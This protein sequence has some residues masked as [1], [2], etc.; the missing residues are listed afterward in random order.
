VSATTEQT[1]AIFQTSKRLVVYP[2]ARTTT[3][4]WV[5]SEPYVGLPMEVD[6]QTLGQKVLAALDASQAGVPHPTD[7]KAMDEPFLR[8]AEEKS[9]ARAAHGSRALT[10]TRSS[11]EIRFY[12][13]KRADRRGAFLPAE[14]RE[15]SVP[16]DASPPDL[17]RQVARA[18]ALCEGW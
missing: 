14:D 3:G 1:A 17:G 16:A 6:P 7:W 9:R 11:G 10:L 15:F 8:A 12:P 18:L 2:M 13:T 5:A 4:L